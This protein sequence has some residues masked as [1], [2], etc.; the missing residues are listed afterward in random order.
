MQLSH[1]T[2]MDSKSGLDNQIDDA[3]VPDCQPFPTLRQVFRVI[4][5]EVGFNIEIKY[6]ILDKVG[7]RVGDTCGHWN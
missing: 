5:P 3:G 6:P 4:P 7:M 2:Q 1:V